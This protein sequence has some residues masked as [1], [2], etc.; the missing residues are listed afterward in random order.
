MRYFIVLL[1]SLFFA[2]VQGCAGVSSKV[3]R[4]SAGTQVEDETIESKSMTRIQ[5]KFKDTAQVTVTSYNRFVLI[6]GTVQND[7]IKTNVE[8][9]VYSVPN[10]KKIADEV[11]VG[12]FPNAS[13][14]RTDSSITHDIKSGISKS[15]SLQSVTIKVATERGIVYLL[16]LATHAEADAAS[17]IASTTSDVKKVVRVFEYID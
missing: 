14:H 11:S 9:I 1:L 16:G 13:S 8:R 10:V 17:E 4:R 5:D 7:D 12:S 2:T 3:D 15:K 6:T